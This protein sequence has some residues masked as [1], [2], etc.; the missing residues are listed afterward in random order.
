MSQFRRYPCGFATARWQEKIDETINPLI[1]DGDRRCQH[2]GGTIHPFYYFETK[3]CLARSRRGYEMQAVVL[4]EGVKV[5]Q[6]ARL[7]DAPRLSER[8]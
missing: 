1:A 8:H 7:I 2:Q 5:I 3:D 6:H 4:Q